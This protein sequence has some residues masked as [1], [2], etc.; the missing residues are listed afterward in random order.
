[1][2]KIKSRGVSLLL[3][4]GLA[5]GATIPA[6]ADDGFY[7]QL[8]AGVQHRESAT[9]EAGT[10]TFETGYNLSGAVGYRVNQ[11]RFELE[12]AYLDN[13][14]STT[15][16]V[17][18]L[19]GKEP[20]SGHVDI[21]SVFLNAYYDL[22]LSNPDFSLYGGLGIG[23]Y[24]VKIHGLTTPTLAN[25]PPVWGGPIIVNGESDWN[26]AFQI[27]AGLNYQVSPRATLFAGYR[28]F[29]GNN[30][31][32]DITQGPNSPPAV[33]H[34]NDPELHNFELGARYYF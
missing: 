17:G 2:L 22:P 14:D 11:A 1:M 6:Q 21:R 31:A 28:Y 8:G 27:K 25:L 4:T 19:I 29:R 30:L 32:I 20:S 33:I 24:Q 23:T 5:L 16:P 12:G 7:G 13:D 26:T 18:P 3:V 34:P 10:T 9:D 15:D